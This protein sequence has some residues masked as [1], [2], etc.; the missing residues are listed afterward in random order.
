MT[1]EFSRRPLKTRNTDWPR[2]LAFRLVRFGLTPNEISLT[3]VALSGIGAACLSLAANYDGLFEAALFLSAA[4]CIQL[5]LIL[6]P[7]QPN[8]SLFRFFYV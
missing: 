1:A 8:R 2:R 6:F 5:R 3:S 4:I 7:T